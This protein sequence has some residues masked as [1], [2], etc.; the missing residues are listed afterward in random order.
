M[1]ARPHAVQ[2]PPP[3]QQLR[4]TGHRDVLR[5]QQLLRSGG[6]GLRLRGRLAPPRIRSPRQAAARGAWEL[7]WELGWQAAGEG[8]LEG[9]PRRLLLLPRNLLLQEGWAPRRPARGCRL[10]LRVA[11]RRG[12]WARPPAVVVASA[13][14]G[15]VVTLLLLRLLLLRLLLLPLLLLPLLVRGGAGMA[16]HLR[17][18]ARP[19]RARFPAARCSRPLPTATTASSLAMLWLL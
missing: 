8:V 15:R 7:R 10:L 16:R 5:D 4:Q 13:A 1:P 11:T 12:H 18:G 14:A 17:T 6:H 19:W 2:Q 3:T 9:W